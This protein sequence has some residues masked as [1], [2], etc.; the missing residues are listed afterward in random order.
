MIVRLTLDVQVP[1]GTEPQKL[2]GEIR[3][4]LG[5]DFGIVTMELLPDSVVNETEYCVPVILTLE[6]GTRT[7]AELIDEYLDSDT[8][9]GR[10]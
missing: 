4:D 7:R 10:N 5:P 8:F 3:R 9:R 2:F 1:D 6:G